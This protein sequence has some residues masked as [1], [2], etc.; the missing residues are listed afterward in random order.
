MEQR[1]K[2]EREDKISLGDGV[3][4]LFL[5]PREEVIRKGSDEEILVGVE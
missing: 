5:E 2:E 4:F 1:L 3:R